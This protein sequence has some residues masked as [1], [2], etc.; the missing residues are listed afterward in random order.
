[1]PAVIVYREPLPDG[2]V[3][4]WERQEDGSL[5]SFV[6]GTPRN[7]SQEAL[8]S[9]APYKDLYADPWYQEHVL[10][11]MNAATARQAAIQDQQIGLQGRGVALQE[12]IG[13]ANIQNQRDLLEQRKHEYRMTYGLQ[14]RGLGLQSRG[15]DLQANLALAQMRGPG[16]AAQYID[17]ARRLRGFGTQSGALAEIAR[18]GMPT[19]GSG[20]AFGMNPISMQD[21]MSG[22]LGASEAQIDERDRNDRGIAR[23]IYSNPGQLARGSLESLSPYERAYLGSYGEAEGFDDEAF[24][25]AYKRAG[26]HQG[27]RVRG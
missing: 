7:P 10:G 16:S 17:A 24:T 11:P 25:E 6:V 20:M 12:R 8:T 27:A 3:K 5:T 13:D 15:Q 19:G 4:V 2:T 18:G 26:I 21:R 14:E 23:Q 1:M 9:L 22:M